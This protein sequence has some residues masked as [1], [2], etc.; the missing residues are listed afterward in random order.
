MK[1]REITQIVQGKFHHYF[2]RYRH[3]FS[4]PDW[5][6][7]NQLCFGILESGELK[8]SKI[9]QGLGEQISLKKTTERLARH[10]GQARFWE[11]ASDA[12]LQVQRW[13]L[14]RC[15]YMLLDLSDIQ[16]S[17]AHKMEGLA[18]VH[19]GSK[20]TVGL[21]YWL[22]N[23]VGVSA[24][25]RTIVPAYSELYSFRSESTSENQKILSAIARIWKVIGKA[26]IW[27]MD[28]GCDRFELMYRLLRE[29][30]YFVVRQR[31]DRDLWYQGKK[32][33]FRTVCRKVEM[34]FEFTVKKRHNNRIIQRTYRA[35]AK[36]IRLTPGGK[37]LWLMVS[38]GQGR[39][40][41]YYLCHLA[42]ENEQEAVELAFRGYGHRWKIEEVHRH[43]KEQYNWEGICLRRY[44]ALKNMNAVFWIA[45]SFIYTQLEAL[46][47]EVFTR[48][49]LIYRNRISELLGFIYY[50]LS[51]AMKMIFSKCTLRLKTLYK[52]DKNN[53]VF[54]LLDMCYAIYRKRR[55]TD[56]ILIDTFSTT[57]FYFAYITSQLARLFKI[58][59]IPILHGGNLPHRLDTS[60]NMADAIFRSSYRNVAP[61]GY[62]KAEFEKRDFDALLIPNT[63]NIRE[64]PFKLRSKLRPRLLYVRAFAKIYN[65]CLAIRVLAELKKHYPCAKLC[66]VGPDKD[67]T[68]REILDLVETLNLK[69]DVEIT[70]VLSKE[71]WH[72]KSTEYDVF[73]N[74][75][76]FDNTPV[77]VMEVMALGLPVVSTNVGG[78]PFL[79]DDAVDGILVERNNTAAMVRAIVYLLGAP[80]VVSK[81]V[82]NARAKVEGFD[83][84][85]VRAKW[86]DVLQ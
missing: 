76:D 26:S 12:L 59:Y 45:V 71:Q 31:S 66:M 44:V 50:K 77:S 25:G 83:W 73:I 70:G 23:I 20:D 2:G 11:S 75:T 80:D 28:R 56:I 24:D 37:D 33:K 84:D 36:R 29:G 60:K 85:V 4:R 21:G 86:I 63:L 35:G 61:S 67:G 81:M 57:S 68:L 39:G 14:R 43:V 1:N 16:K 19:D 51:V 55:G 8:L 54:R 72:R 47:L 58:P 53:Q 9:A 10:L 30:I 13:S 52:S 82:L 49:N 7:V 40:Y 78:V 65:P 32:R 41:C 79:I 48:L 27:V 62:L 17:Y 5:K 3:Y 34:S 38:K 74:T 42:T 46:P 69:D 6:F 18:G 64:Y 15:R 22:L